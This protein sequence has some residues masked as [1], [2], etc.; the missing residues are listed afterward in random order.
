ML[1]GEHDILVAEWFALC[2]ARGVQ[3]PWVLLPVLLLR[4]RRQPELDV[5]VRRVAG[6]RARWLADAVPELGV[7]P[8][9]A[10]PKTPVE[11]LSPPPAIAD[12]AAMVSTL[13][14][15]FAERAVTWAVAPQLRQVV[16]A[17]D[18]A[19]HPRLVAELSALPFDPSSERT[20]REIIALAEFRAEM[21]R[22]F[23]V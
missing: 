21:I 12:S 5:V 6:E 17:L 7:R 8:V 11:P 23:A 19:W 1:R 9:P 22:D 20:R 2:D 18:P 14:G 16:A 15:A 4:G 10:R 3:L 13:V